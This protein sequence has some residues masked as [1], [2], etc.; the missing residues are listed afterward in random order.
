MTARLDSAPL[1]VLAS[2]LLAAGCGGGD[3]TGPGPNPDD[4]ATQIAAAAGNNQ[5]GAVGAALSSAIAVRVTNARG[6]GVSG[7][8]V[9][10]AVVS[11]GGAV[12]PSS[13]STDASGSAAATWTLG[14]TPRANTAT[15]SATGLAGSP[16][17]FTATAVVGL[18]S[19]LQ[20]LSGDGQSALFGSA[21]TD[22]LRRKPP[23]SPTACLAL[24][25]AAI[26]LAACGK[27]GPVTRPI[28]NLPRQLTG[29]EAGLVE[30][31]N[32][33]TFALLR[34]SL[35][36]APAGTNVFVSPLSVSLAPGMTLN[37]AAGTT[38]DSPRAALQLEGLTPEEIKRRPG[39][40]ALTAR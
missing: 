12:S 1:A 34:E 35:R 22:S 20:K 19:S 5:T 6:T 32:R 31:D 24:T 39:R 21:V 36:N 40:S 29:A 2:L 17:T 28:T 9:G 37:G 26:T 33:F 4:Q 13:A 10:F 38:F 15:A 27:D 16:V 23:M 30:A 7:V 18:A 3:S 14:T 25:A 11:G 8:A